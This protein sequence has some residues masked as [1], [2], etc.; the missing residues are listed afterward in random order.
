MIWFH[1]LMCI[2]ML[3][4]FSQANFAS[5]EKCSEICGK[6]VENLEKENLHFKT[7]FQSFCTKIIQEIH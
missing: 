2:M 7:L 4:I 3:L 1:K 6:S 5:S